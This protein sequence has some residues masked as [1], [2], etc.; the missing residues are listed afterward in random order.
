MGGIGQGLGRGVE[1]GAEEQVLGAH[2]M[3][4][5]SLQ[6]LWEVEMSGS[7]LL[8]HLAAPPADSLLGGLASKS[9]PD[10]RTGAGQ[11]LGQWE[12]NVLGQLG[13]GW[14]EAP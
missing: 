12:T 9:L 7:A 4:E 8:D 13:V 3:E 1:W 11:K 5:G 2:G 14:E 6:R 10:G